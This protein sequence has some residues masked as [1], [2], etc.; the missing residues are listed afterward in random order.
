MSEGAERTLE[1]DPAAYHPDALAA[2]A[3]LFAGRAE[4]WL[5]EDE[6]TLRVSDPAALDALAAEFLAEVN[7]QELRRRIAAANRT[8]R[9]YI[10]TQALLSAA[11]ERTSS[12]A[13]PTTRTPDPD[14]RPDGEEAGE[15]G[16]GDDKPLDP[17]DIL[18]SWEKSR[19]RRETR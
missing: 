4:V 3:H 10:I 12:P 1:F 16:E 19:E 7:V 2:A 5:G 6:V 14:P 11:G 13:T 17:D 9:E 18:G 15:G 8:L